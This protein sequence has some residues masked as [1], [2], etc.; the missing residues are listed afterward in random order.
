MTI[1]TLLFIY[2][3]DISTCLMLIKILQKSPKWYTRSHQR[4]VPYIILLVATE[5]IGN[6]INLNTSAINIFG[7]VQLCLHFRLFL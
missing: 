1:F 3:Y 7:A 2:C 5:V 6:F 4:T